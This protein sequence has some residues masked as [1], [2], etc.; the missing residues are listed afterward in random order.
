MTAGHFYIVAAAVMCLCSTFL[1]LHCKYEDGLIGRIA[2]AALAILEGLIVWE[3]WVDNV[4]P[5]VLPASY[6]KEIAITL[7]FLRHV[8]RFMRWRLYGEHDWREPVK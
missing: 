1:V 5:Q 8:Y 2:L 6:W 7:F 4:I 3:W